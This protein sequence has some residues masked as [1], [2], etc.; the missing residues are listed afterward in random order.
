MQTNSIEMR[1]KILKGYGTIGAEDL[2][3]FRQWKPEL[4]EEDNKKLVLEGADELLNLAERMQNRFPLLLSDTFS[5]DTY[6]VCFQS[7]V[8]VS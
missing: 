8:F 4:Y 7:C 2:S 6:R 5:N 1:D 3:L